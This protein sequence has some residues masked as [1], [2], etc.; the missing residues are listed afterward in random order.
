MTTDPTVPQAERQPLPAAPAAPAP[1][2]AAPLPAAPAD[3]VHFLDYW[4]ILYSRKEIVIAVSILLIL[5]GI[6]VT[7]R[8]PKV[9]A[10]QAV[11]EVQ[12]ETPSISLY[13]QMQ[14]RYDPIF[15]R[16]QFEII[17][18]DPVIEQVVREANLDQDLGREYGWRATASQKDTFERTVALV[19]RKTDLSIFRDTDLISIE[20]R[21]EKPEKPDGE[22]A[23]VAARV[24]NTLAKVFKDYTRNKS[25]G[26]I[27]EGLQKL[28]EEVKELERQISAKEDELRS[29]R[30]KYGITLLGEG[31]TGADI[32]RKQI[33]DFTARAEN[34]KMTADIK[35]SRYE[36]IVEL[37][38]DVAA[39]SIYA[40]TGDSSIT[41]LLTDKTKTELQLASQQ[42]AGL[43]PRHPDVVQTTTILEEIE[44]KIRTKVDEVKTSLRLDWEQ[45]QAEAEMYNNQLKKF[46]ETERTLSSG[47]SIEM[48]KLNKD[49][50]TLKA[51]RMQI[52]SRMDDER[53]SLDMPKTSVEIVQAAKVPE[54]PLPVSPNFA[55]NVTLSV[56]AGL[57]F[58]VVL[59][60]F[61]EY[62]DT[63]V[64]TAEDVERYLQTN[65]VGIVPQKLRNL[66]SPN[67]RLTH[68]E[69]Y[70]V[71]RM[72]LKNDRSLGTGKI[73]VV[74]SASA[75]EG[76]SLNAF[77]LAWICAE[78]GEKTLLVD[79]DLYHPRQHRTLGVSLQPGLSNI[80]VGESS[81][82]AAIVSTQQANLDFLPAGRIASA[83]VFGL[84]D[85]DEMSEFFKK[86]R[87]RY[88]R[89]IVD[90]PPMI[91]V[92]DTAQLV[93]LGDGVLQVV[94]HRKYPRALCRRAKERI[95]AMGGNYLGVLLNNVNAAHG[96]A[97]Y[98]YEHQY[99]YY[100]TSDADG[101]MA[102]HRRRRH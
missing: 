61:V 30:N 3:A 64:K 63:T 47:V 39:T 9:Y 7:R 28:G 81:I 82:D 79:A 87:D 65:L 55:L 62:L 91:G 29:L 80:V 4:Q 25:K 54:I 60:F 1:V 14:V 67:A 11:I 18:S 75:G 69:V 84:M 21:L 90:A 52:E 93:R 19:K 71:L 70:R 22:A 100:Y 51:R 26:Q 56:V 42:R 99:Y 23:K 73:L 36:H 97:S 50:A 83:S 96:S 43:G 102:H 74:T 15:L 46:S 86:I 6:V 101:G 12:R 88:D 58:G 72:S 92:S 95:V 78:C 40:L 35:R 31:D 13:N 38:P 34:A 5:V 16:T 24:A 45:A 41:P 8:M 89:I 59:A 66:N 2:P 49:I 32:V 20:V 37:D 33:A 77:N 76:K 53:I 57:F 27:E 17:K 10:A 85:T 48:E 44:S 94:H 68:Y 98:Y